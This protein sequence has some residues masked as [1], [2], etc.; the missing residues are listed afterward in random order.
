[1]ARNEY[2]PVNIWMDMPLMEFSEWVH[3]AIELDKEV[4]EAG[5]NGS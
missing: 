2:T 4:R 1:M 5:G 3:T